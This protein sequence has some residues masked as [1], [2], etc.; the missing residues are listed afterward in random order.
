MIIDTRHAATPPPYNY[1]ST[2]GTKNNAEKFIVAPSPPQPPPP[3]PEKYNNHAS[4][5]IAH[6]SQLSMRLSSLRYWSS[7]AAQVP[8]SK[9]RSKD[10]KNRPQPFLHSAAFK[11]VTAWLADDQ[12]SAIMSA[13]HVPLDMSNP[14]PC[15][16]THQGDHS[17]ILRDIFCASHR[18]LE[19]LRLLQTNSSIVQPLASMSRSTTSPNINNNSSNHMTP[20][21]RH[22]VMAC[23]ALLLETYGAILTVLHYDVQQYHPN[24]NA[25]TSNTLSLTTAL[26]NVRL[27]LVVQLCSYLIE[28]QHRAVDQC[29]GTA[30]PEGRPLPTPPGLASFQGL[31][32][33][34]GEALRQL[35]DLVQKQLDKLE[36]VLRNS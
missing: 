20:I 27:V 2:T 14:Y 13:H 24:T 19:I 31:D 26:G 8:S 5:I 15:P 33:G 10:N 11:S 36:E 23:N 29:F 34:D 4:L 32:A 17:A 9:P 7:T 18:L 30:A 35:K 21:I 12:C 3:P 1:G 25:P 6:L 16:E 22:L 28:R